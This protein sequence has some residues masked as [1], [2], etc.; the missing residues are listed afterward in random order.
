MRR[1]PESG[2]IEIEWLPVFTTQL[3]SR[4]PSAGLKA[5]ML[6]LSHP[7]PFHACSILFS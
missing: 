4:I 6:V 3:L 7:T 1:G 5:F 2:E